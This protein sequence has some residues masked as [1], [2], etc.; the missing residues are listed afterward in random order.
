MDDRKPYSGLKGYFSIFFYI[1]LFFFG[2]YTK[3]FCTLRGRGVQVRD[4]L[5]SYHFGEGHRIIFF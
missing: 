4:W 5:F 1:F 2:W 3:A